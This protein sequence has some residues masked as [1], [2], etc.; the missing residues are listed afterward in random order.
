MK[1]KFAFLVLLL[2]IITVAALSQP[3]ASAVQASS[4]ETR[5]LVGVWRGQG[6][7]QQNGL[8]FVTLT[9]GNEGGNLSGAILLSVVHV[10]EG[11]IITS[12]PGVP[13]PILNPRFDGQTL[14]FQVK[15]RGPVH[16]GISSDPLLTFRLRMT[17]ANNGAQATGDLITDA[18]PSTG[19]PLP[20][21]PSIQMVKGDN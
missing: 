9:V 2:G 17:S 6:E 8:P 15:Y 4:P 1:T 16:P 5:A 13:E 14:T 3:A 20:L 7:A 10:E 18:E 21:G 11:K 12:A 19:S